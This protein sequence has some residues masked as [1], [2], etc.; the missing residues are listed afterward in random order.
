VRFDPTADQAAVRDTVRAFARAKLAP[1]YL[2]RAK[3][4]TFP[5][6]EH[7]A[8]ADLGVLGMLAGPEHNPLP[9]EDFV[10]VGLA[11]EE[12]A[13]ADFNLANAVIPVLLMS[14]LVARH[15]DAAARERWLGPLVRGE[16]Y[17]ALGLTE[18]DAGSDVAAIRASATADGDGYVLHGEKTSVTMLAHAD[19]ILLVARTIRDG[20]AVGVSTFVVPLD[21]PGVER[22]P[23]AD[24]GWLP[25][26]RGVLRLD[27][28][29]IPASALVGQR[30]Q[31]SAACSAASK[32]CFA[33]TGIGCAQACIDETAEYLRAGMPSAHR[34]PGSRARRSSLPSTPPSSRPLD[35]CA[36]RRCGGVP[37]A[38]PTRPWRP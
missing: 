36:T 8:V 6:G 15:G 1:G 2:E 17:M 26:G 5:W 37:R 7:R 28:V 10:A 18:P 35:C 38:Y 11:V 23:I 19:A 20:A 12:L 13:Y 34:S 31:P 32:C 22:H 33:L 3:S 14:S 24:T 29:R 27:G 4:E 21:P 16:V 25:M 30:A 9:T